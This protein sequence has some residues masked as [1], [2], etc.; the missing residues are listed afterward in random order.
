MSP[1]SLHIRFCSDQCLIQGL[2]LLVHEDLL[3]GADVREGTHLV[4]G[5]EDAWPGLARAAASNS[6]LEQVQLLDSY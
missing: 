2:G 3:S 5:E 1:G 6:L 4:K